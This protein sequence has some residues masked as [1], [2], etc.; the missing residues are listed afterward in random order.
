MTGT[1]PHLLI[2]ADVLADIAAAAAAAYP[3]EC[4]GL[5]VGCDDAAGWRV[6]RWQPAANVH[7]SPRRHFE[8]DPAVHIALLRQ[9]REAAGIE[10]LLGHV[11]SHPDAPAEPSAR[12]RALAHDREMLWMIVSSTA[13]QAVRIAV[14]QPSS[15]SAE[16][17]E[18]REI[19]LAT[20]NE[21]TKSEKRP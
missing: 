4:C 12:D 11:H 5:L 20:D 7:P 19:S 8:L 9:L 13:T 21:M 3:L 14:W 1:A 16:M 17:A 6:T 2:G 18:F 10:R 15:N